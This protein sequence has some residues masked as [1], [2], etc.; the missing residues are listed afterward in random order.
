MKE[1]QKGAHP[2]LPVVE[3]ITASG[4]RRLRGA[5]IWRNRRPRLACGQ[6]QSTTSTIF[7]RHIIAAHAK[8]PTVLDNT[9]LTI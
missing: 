4:D 6:H 1:G 8:R 9:Q 7:S 5:R 2:E 3:L